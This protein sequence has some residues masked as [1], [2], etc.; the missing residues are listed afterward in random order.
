MALIEQ[1]VWIACMIGFFVGTWRLE[2]YSARRY[3][4]GFFSFGI[5]C[6]AMIAFAAIALGLWLALTGTR[7]QTAGV[8]TACAGAL[9]YAKIVFYNFF[10]TDW[11]VGLVGSVAQLVVFLL[12]AGLGVIPFALALVFLPYLFCAR[13]AD[14][15][16]TVIYRPMTW[17]RNGD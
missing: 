8:L 11:L 3:D 9:A 2:L 10:R 6:L 14:T 16:P 4:H 1:F 17:Y 13:G 7:F 12:A 15:S 5:F